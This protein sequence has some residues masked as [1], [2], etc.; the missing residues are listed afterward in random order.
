MNDKLGKMEEKF[1]EIIWREEPIPSGELVKICASEFDWKK[2]TTYTMLKRLC[3]RGITVNENGIVKALVSKENYISAQSKNFIDE[4]F[5][6]S[7]PSFLTAFTKRNK[8]TENDIKEIQS[9]IDKYKE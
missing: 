9:F 1:A 5:N 3:K 2:S 8:L 7:L 6:G 4:R